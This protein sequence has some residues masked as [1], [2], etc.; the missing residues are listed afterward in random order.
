MLWCY[1]V[2][3][4]SQRSWTHIKIDYQ[5]VDSFP[6]PRLLYSRPIIAETLKS[7]SNSLGLFVKSAYW[8]LSSWLM[9]WQ[10]KLGCL[11][12]YLSSAMAQ[13]VLCSRIF[14]PMPCGMASAHTRLT[15]ASCWFCLR[16][17]TEC[18]LYSPFPV[19]RC[20]LKTRSSWFA[21]ALLS[22]L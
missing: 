22:Y 15:R 8:F 3:F 16:P 20:L 7:W 1:L 13:L 2:H 17:P 18:R 19:L 12:S 21:A 9:S 4:A 10:T 14:Y 6:K 5:C 11:E